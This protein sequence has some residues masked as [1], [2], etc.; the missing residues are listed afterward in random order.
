MTVTKGMAMP[1]ERG[2]FTLVEGTLDKFDDNDDGLNSSRHYHHQH[3]PNSNPHCP[4]QP[5]RS[6]PW[7]D[8]LLGDIVEV[9]PAIVS[10]QSGV[11]GCCNVAD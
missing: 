6:S 7:V 1:I 5:S 10:P 3:F 8:D 9:V 11:K 4:S 2:R